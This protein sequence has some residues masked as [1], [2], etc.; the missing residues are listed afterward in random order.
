MAAHGTCGSR[1]DHAYTAIGVAIA[2]S[3]TGDIICREVGG[4]D[5]SCAAGRGEETHAVGIS[6]G[7]EA[8]GC[9]VIA[10]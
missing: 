8:G 5:T 6:G 1:V 4:V 9:I 2:S 3:E 10:R 7:A